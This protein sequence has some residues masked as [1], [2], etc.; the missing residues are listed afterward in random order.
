MPYSSAIAS[1]DISSRCSSRLNCAARSLCVASNSRRRTK[2][3]TTSKLIFTA[4][5]DL[6]TLA[7]CSAQPYP[8]RPLRLI[9]AAA[10]GS[11][12]DIAARNLAPELTKQ[13]GHQVVVDNRPGASGI[14]G[15][16]MIARAVPDGHTFGL[17]T[18][19]F[20]A[21]PSL[22]TRLPYDSIKDFDPIILFASNSNLLAVAPSLPIRSIT[23]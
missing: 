5:S 12:Q 15:T 22:F 7:S 14:I 21:V 11:A 1:S 18:N 17:L 4:R 16:E 19:T 2:A 23:R 9:V 6:S 3:R 10:A 20:T 8:N 13:M